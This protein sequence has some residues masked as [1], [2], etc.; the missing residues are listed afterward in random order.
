MQTLSS[1]SDTCRA[2]R[3]ASENT[4]TVEMPISLQARMTRTAISPRLAINSLGNKFMPPVAGG[5]RRVEW[6]SYGMMKENS[7]EAHIWPSTRA[8]PL[9]T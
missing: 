9:T 1:A 7:P 4:A 2:S 3:S 5:L 8:S 6:R